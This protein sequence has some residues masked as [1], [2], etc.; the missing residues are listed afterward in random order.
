[1]GFACWAVCP[2]CVTAVFT[3]FPLGLGEIFSET[4]L[5]RGAIAAGENR[6]HDSA[7]EVTQDVLWD[8][9][10]TQPRIVCSF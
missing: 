9:V 5:K 7:P 8:I 3:Y 10:L 1:M 4:A 6:R 2:S